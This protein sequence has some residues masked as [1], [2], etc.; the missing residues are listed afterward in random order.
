MAIS[1]TNIGTGFS[2]A[3]ATTAAI[4]VPAGGIPAGALIVVAVTENATIA[5]GGSIADSSGTN[6]YSQITSAANATQGFGAIWYA[7]NVAALVSGNTIT[8][9]RASSLLDCSISAFYAT[10][11]LT[12]SP[13]DTG[14]TASAGPASSSSPS[15]TSGIPAVS[16][17][18]FVAMVSNNSVVSNVNVTFTQDTTH[19]WAVPFTESIATGASSYAMLDGGNQ[20]NAGSSAKIF[21]PTLSGAKSVAIMVVGFKP[22]ASVT[23]VASFT[24]AGAL[25][26]NAIGYVS[27]A[28]KFSGSGLLNA[29]ATPTMFSGA[30]FIGVG[31]LKAA[32]YVYNFTGA[33]F[34]GTGLLNANGFIGVVTGTANFNGAGAL[35]VN[36]L[37]FITGVANFAGT[38]LLNATAA[39]FISGVSSFSGVGALN[40]TA[41]PFVSGVANF[42]GVGA[43]N[44]A[45]FVFNFTGANFAGAGLLNTNALGYVVGSANFNGA[46]AL[47]A[48]AA[49]YVFGVADFS[50]VG[51]LNANASPFVIGVSNFQGAGLLNANALQFN[52][53]AASFQGAGSLN[54]GVGGNFVFGYA[55]FQGAGAL[56]FSFFFPP[57]RQAIKN[58]FA[59]QLVYSVQSTNQFTTPNPSLPPVKVYQNEPAHLMLRVQDIPQVPVY[60]FITRPDGTSY[61][62]DQTYIYASVLRHGKFLDY[63]SAVGEF[64]QMGWWL[65]QYIIGESI[66]QQFSFY[67]TPLQ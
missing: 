53:G 21:N 12:T 5:A 55:D 52:F 6:S 13:V 59:T 20:V 26:A 2:N 19:G 14:V 15:I 31:S 10:G 64:N 32:D 40:A 65:A 25:N 57:A 27:V 37:P 42:A 28:A 48:N 43:L 17:E 1:V 61:Y 56:N 4:T 67:I 18:L 30:N 58:I 62:V 11:I 3:T 9:T 45:D 63:T 16:G 33:S 23:G 54:A 46:G 66:S 39:P 41:S 50:G 38:G 24:G 49:G 8:Y 35:N 51:A 44:V 34:A 60:L 22:A 7:A 36:A 47:N 29:N